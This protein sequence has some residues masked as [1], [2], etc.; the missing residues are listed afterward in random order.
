MANW[1]KVQNAT[2]EVAFSG[3]NQKTSFSPFL[4]FF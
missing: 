1:I 3:L 4:A 2:S